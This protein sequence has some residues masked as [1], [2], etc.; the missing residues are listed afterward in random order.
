MKEMNIL[1]VNKD[2]RLSTWIDGKIHFPHFQWKDPKSGILSNIKVLVD[3]D[4]YAFIT[5][6]IIGLEDIS[7]TEVLEALRED[8]EVVNKM[9]IG[10]S[11]IYL[12]SDYN[13]LL[14]KVNGVIERLKESEV[15][16]IEKCRM[17]NI[18]YHANYRLELDKFK[19]DL[20][21]KN[22]KLESSEID[23]IIG[24]L[25]LGK[26][27]V[28][29]KLDIRLLDQKVV[30]VKEVVE[31][32]LMHVENYYFTESKGKYYRLHE[33][34]DY[35]NE[36]NITDIVYEALIERGISIRTSP[37]FRSTYRGDDTNILELIDSGMATY[38]ETK[39]STNLTASGIWFTAKGYE[40]LQGKKREVL[41][42]LVLSS[43]QSYES[44]AKTLGKHCTK[45]TIKEIAQLN[46]KKLLA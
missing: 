25:G 24:C 28:G 21:V 39:S 34:E 16:V 32:W 4:S 30:H 1:T 40:Q 8:E 44:K 46:W 17:G 35:K 37:Y 42:K 10:E 5:G 15:K 2:G 3:K 33:Y 20:M 45:E 7:M 38:T 41:E 27:R 22:N 13:T 36:E 18:K 23:R 6:E 9:T 11:Y 43:K 14:V 29:S 26:F 31:G 19:T 12:L